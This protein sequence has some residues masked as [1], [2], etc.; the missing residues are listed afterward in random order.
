MFNS[1]QEAFDSTIEK[2]VAQ[3]KRSVRDDDVCL[4]LS[5]DGSKCA[6]GVHIPDGHDAQSD[7]GSVCSVLNTYPDIL[8]KLAVVGEQE[9]AY[10]DFWTLLQSIHD[11]DVECDVLDD[12]ESIAKKYEVDTSNDRLELWHDTFQ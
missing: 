6:I 7:L 12:L 8:E 1:Y 11:Q 5:H 4:Y 9:V 2:L 3:G 10:I